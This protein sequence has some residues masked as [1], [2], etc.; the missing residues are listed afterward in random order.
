[1]NYYGVIMAG[2]GGERFWPLSRRECPK[3]FL[4]LTGREIMVNEALKRLTGPCEKEKLF[5]VT[6]ALQ[7]QKMKTLT[8]EY[9]PEG[10][11]LVEPVG[12]NTAACI[13]YAAVSL[14]KKFGDGV[15]IV[16]PSDAY[17]R[18]EKE[19]QRVT[20][21]AAKAAEESDAVVTVGISPTFPSTGYGYLSYELSAEEVKR[22]LRFV[23]K[24]DLKTAEG[25]LKQG[26][27]L[28]NSGMFFFRISHILG[29]YRKF[30]PELYEGLQKIGKAIGTSEEEKRV[31]EIY[32]TL[33]SISV[34]FGIMEKAEV[35][36]VVPGD[37]GWSDLGSFEA[38]SSVYAPDADGNI[39]L[40]DTC[41]RDVNDC[42]ILSKKKLVAAIG[43]QNLIV[44]ET[45][46]ALLICAK[47]RAQE[48][49]KTVE[50]LRARGREDL[51]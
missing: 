28:W 19:F 1:M 38:L 47:D 13:G 51:L 15:M 36:Y 49:K 16:T 26:N 41:L 44:V 11:I 50:M 4:N 48:I 29:L 40:G 25:Y 39:L 30:L 10:N 5:V 22:V 43:V 46:D 7:A 18:D 2:G 8:R 24:P 35:I 21:L 33:Q 17:I 34:D 20:F 6:N 45:D 9:L 31:S 14:L 42:V 12:R 3:Q 32:P 27:Y 37:F 23:E